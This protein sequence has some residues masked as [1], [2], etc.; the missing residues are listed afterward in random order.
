M[1]Q[2]SYALKRTTQHAVVVVEDS[3]TL[4]I[5]HDGTTPTIP[6]SNSLLPEGHGS[7]GAPLSGHVRLMGDEI[8]DPFGQIA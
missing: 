3:V 1:L 2:Q 7:S 4:R 6:G 8:F 5:K